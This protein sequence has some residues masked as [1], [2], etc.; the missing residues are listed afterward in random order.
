MEIE[1]KFWIDRFP[2]LPCAVHK[3][4]EQGYLTV[5]PVE[6]RIRKSEDCDTGAVTY[7]LTIKSMG[8]LERHEVETDLTPQQYQE[9]RGLMAHPMIEKDYRAYR[10]EDGYTLEC[11]IVDGGVFAYAE[12]EFPSVEAAEAWQP[13]PCLGR[14]TTY[15]KGFKMHTYWSDRHV[16]D[17]RETT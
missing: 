14:E 9:L 8:E 12:V 5:D 6:V 13:L 4:T 1:R 10:L 3:K 7:R 2:E 11:S 16:P 15:E 17:G